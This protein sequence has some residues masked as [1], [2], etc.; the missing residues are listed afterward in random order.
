MSLLEFYVPHLQKPCCI[1][2]SMLYERLLQSLCH[3]PYN[4]NLTRALNTILLKCCLPSTDTFDRLEKIHIRV[5]RF[6]VISCK[7]ASLKSTRFPKNKG[8]ILFYANEKQM[9]LLREQKLS[10]KKTLKYSHCDISLCNT[11]CSWRT[12]RNKIWPMKIRV[13]TCVHELI[14]QNESVR[15]K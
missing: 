5:P 12:I 2:T 11:G 13:T 9:Q 3:F 7:H 1:T 4:E 8:Q 15:R 14:F 10:E 6:K